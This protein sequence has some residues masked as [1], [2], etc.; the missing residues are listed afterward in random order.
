MAYSAITQPDSYSN[1]Y[2]FIPLRLTDDNVTNIEN[3]KYLTNI[4][5]NEI[6]VTSSESYNYNGGIYTKLTFSSAHSF[7][8]GDI[9][10]LEQESQFYTD[11]YIVKLVPDTT[12][13]VIDL[14][15]GAAL[16]GS[17]SVSN[18]I[19]YKLSPDP[20]NEAKI[21]LSNTLKDFVTQDFEDSNSIFAGPNTKFS[22][23][24]KCGYEGNA[25]FEFDDNVF[26]SGNVGF[27]A[28][29]LT[30]TTQVDFNIGD[31]IIVQQNLFAW[32][33]D[34]NYFAVGSLVGF[35]GSTE[36]GS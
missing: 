30:A 11:Y 9:L 25:L 16:T 14:T 10:L 31:E 21:D 15:L 12:S 24:L 4:V 28:T 33:Y 20:D 36:P 6:D 13:V 2:S 27:V 29:G 23:D 3:Y 22:F 5:Y 19:K 8:V 17:T 18:V 34:D 1:G 26:Q 32:N 35:T 7:N